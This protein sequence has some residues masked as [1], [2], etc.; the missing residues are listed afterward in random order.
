[1][2]AIAM[3]PTSI[4]ALKKSLSHEFDEVKSS[5][6]SEAVAYSLGYR[7]SAALLAAMPAVPAQDAPFVLL[8]SE[9]MLE[10]LGQL[11]YPRRPR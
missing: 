1:M 4:A 3:T 11:G 2:A 5:H 7:T 8:S 9:R 10:R 6:L